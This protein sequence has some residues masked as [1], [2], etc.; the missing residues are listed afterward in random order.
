MLMKLVLFIIALTGRLVAG[1]LGF[2]FIAVGI[3]LCFTIIGAIIGV[4]LVI[5]GVLLMVASFS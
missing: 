5:L 2:V 1:V 3:L 4:P